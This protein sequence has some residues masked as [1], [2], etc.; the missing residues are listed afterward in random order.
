MA[1]ASRSSRHHADVVDS[2]PDTWFVLA[3][4]RWLDNDTL[5]A[6]HWLD[7]LVERLVTPATED[8]TSVR[9]ACVRLM[10]ARLGSEPL[11]P[12]MC[13]AR[14]V[15]RA[16]AGRPEPQPLLPLL[17]VELGV[18]ETS[19]DEL[20]A[21][22][23]SLT[24]AASL[25]RTRGLTTL[26]AAALS[27]LALN[28]HMQGR[29]SCSGDVADQALHLMGG[30]VAWKPDYIEARA[31]L[32]RDLARLSAPGPARAAPDSG[33]GP[34]DSPWET[35]HAADPVAQ[36]WHRIR[37]ARRSLAS[38]SV[39]DAEQ[40]LQLPTP[41]A[42]SD[43]LRVVLLVELGLLAYLADDEHALPALQTELEALG[44][45]GEADLLDGIRHELAGKRKAA[46][47]AYAAA[48]DTATCA[49]PATR[50]FA[51]AAQAQ[52]LD[53]LGEGDR[54]MELLREATTTT[55]VR[56]NAAPFL[57]W[58]RQGTPI[59]TLLGRL[60]ERSPT[61]GASWPRPPLATRT[62]SPPWPRSRLRRVSAHRS[63]TTSSGRR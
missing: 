6:G 61:A 36:F 18:A 50:A 31:T 54:A 21:A 33:P 37:T 51:L 38:G 30:E 15:V 23:T 57:G 44:A 5:G 25:C 32:A 46:A 12:A 3:L 41:S 58:S 35:V 1:K 7:H 19:T 53:V 45:T 22:E 48:A 29:E 9:G 43:D 60:L 8:K 11:T 17:L 4:E 59:Q 10:R 56:R 40:L 39:V 55:A 13:R 20:D 47:T 63:P 62:S 24:S 28:L 49:Q 16:Q 26:E 14:A 2:H 27:H 42:V 34:H 52:V